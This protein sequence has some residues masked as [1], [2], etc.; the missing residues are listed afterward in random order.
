MEQ[1]GTVK[2]EVESESSGLVGFGFGLVGF[3]F[4]LV[5]LKF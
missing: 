5:G 2:E 3:E 1:R 4:R